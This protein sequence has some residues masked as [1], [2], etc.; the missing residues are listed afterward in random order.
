MSDTKCIT[1]LSDKSSGSTILQCELG[2]QQG[3][4]RLFDNRVNYETKFWLYAATIL[5]L[6]QA[7]M[8]Y[9]HEFPATKDHCMRQINTLLASLGI[10]LRIEEDTNRGTIFAAWHK[11]VNSQRAIL[12]EKSP[13]H[14][15]NW[16]ALLLMAEYSRLYP[17][18]STK[19]I[20]LIRNPLDTLYSMWNRWYARPSLR[21]YEWLRAY[22]NLDNFRQIARDDMIIVRYEDLMTNVRCYMR[23]LDFVGVGPEIQVEPEFHTAS[24]G[25]WK[26][27]AT[28][29][30]SLDDRVTEFSQ[31]F[32]KRERITNPNTSSTWKTRE[33]IY[34]PMF[35]LVVI[36]VKFKQLAARILHSLKQITYRIWP[37]RRQ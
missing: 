15:H 3:I 35:R 25:K 1:I 9:S 5:G 26:E 34:S 20:G 12:I 29:G 10:D 24:I 11:I 7:R 8:K 17:H 13:H 30:F 16:Q 21:Q 14:L 18:S 31:R 37:N 6:P 36:R 32:Y 27:D 33:R 23:I 28:F 2:R 4:F 19:Y 22:E